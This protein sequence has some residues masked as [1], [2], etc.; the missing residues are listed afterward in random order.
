VRL[1][2]LL[3]ELD[4]PFGYLHNA[5]N[6]ANYTL[7]ALLLLMVRGFQDMVSA[8]TDAE[9]SVV[10]DLK[11]MAHFHLSVPTEAQFPGFSG[12]ESKVTR[13]RP[14]RGDQTHRLGGISI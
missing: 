13:K 5:G 4:C 2:H 6:D 14:T 8:L 3:Q 7:R 9:R 10:S 1:G 12:I 11:S